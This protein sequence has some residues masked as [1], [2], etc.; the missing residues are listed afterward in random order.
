MTNQKNRFFHTGIF[1]LPGGRGDVHGAVS[2]GSQPDG[3]VF[4][5]DCLSGMAGL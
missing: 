2:A 5:Y 3:V 1:L 4:W